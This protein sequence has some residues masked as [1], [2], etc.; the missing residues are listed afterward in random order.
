MQPGWHGELARQ[1]EQVVPPAPESM[2]PGL[3]NSYVTAK[4]RSCLGASRAE[5]REVWRFWAMRKTKSNIVRNGDGLV[6][7][8]ES[9]GCGKHFLA[10]PL[11]WRCDVYY[12][13]LLQFHRGIT[14]KTDKTDKM[15]IQLLFLCSYLDMLHNKFLHSHSLFLLTAEACQQNKP[16]R[17][18]RPRK[19]FFFDTFTSI[20]KRVL[21]KDLIGHVHW[22][23]ARI[24][25]D[26]KQS[27]PCLCLH[28]PDA[29][30]LNQHDKAWR[31]RSGEKSLSCSEIKPPTAKVG[32][33]LDRG[34]SVNEPENVPQHNTNTTAAKDPPKHF[35]SVTKP[36]KPCR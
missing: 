5:K 34:G 29:K 17:W 12:T 30:W 23:D 4:Q 31:L 9:R 32:R 16:W 1:C 13:I 18:Y 27:R 26:L 28:W 19:Q 20:E 35:T 7:L 11:H 10:F 21:K 15:P 24:A 25:G 14:V 8:W 22:V 2:N 3:N 36:R 33:E 6:N